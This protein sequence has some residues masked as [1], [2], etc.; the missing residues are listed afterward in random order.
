M[1]PDLHPC[2]DVERMK[3]GSVASLLGIVFGLAIA[4]SAGAAEAFEVAAGGESALPQ[5][6]E[7][8]GIRGDFVLRND[9]V[10]A[11]VSQNSPLR[12]ANMSTFYGAEGVTPG[13]LYDL[14]LRDSANDQLIYFG[15]A[16]QKGTVSWV[17]L[18][19]NT[20]DKATASV[21][22]VTTAA[23][24]GGIYKRHEYRI[25][26]GDQGIWIISTFRNETSQVQKVNRKDDW[27]RFNESGIADGIHWADAVDPADKAGYAY[28]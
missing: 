8:D 4:R 2:A 19:P 28:T 26:D 25:R 22:T 9:K 14:T 7:A 20:K 12:R 16:S 23:K 17:R 10:V 27:T 11:L 18:V 1:L 24:S 21:E 5:G 13:C 3:F 15:P 6:K